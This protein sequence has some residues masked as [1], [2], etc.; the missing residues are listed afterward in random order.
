MIE[1]FNR[2]GLWPYESETSAN[3][4][5][6]AAPTAAMTALARSAPTKR[7][8]PVDELRK[9]RAG[10][11]DGKLVSFSNPTLMIIDEPGCLPFAPTVAHLFTATQLPCT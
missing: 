1:C 9:R 3:Q 5:L 11:L 4:L 10:G 8:R 6:A 7:P 2:S